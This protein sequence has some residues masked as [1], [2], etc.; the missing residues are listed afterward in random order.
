MVMR[1]NDNLFGKFNGA[2]GNVTFYVRDGKQVMAQRNRRIGNPR[3]EAQMAQRIKLAN[4]LSVYR[5]LRDKLPA[6][7][8][9]ASDGGRAPSSTVYNRFTGINLLT[10]PVFL[11][12]ELAR[13]GACVAAPYRV[14]DGALPAIQLTEGPAG[15]CTDILLGDLA[16]TEETS[17]A[18]FTEAVV[19][20]NPLYEEGDSIAYVHLLQTLPCESGVPR[21]TPLFYSVR[22]DAADRRPLRRLVPALGFSAR[23]G[24]L[25]QEGAV[26]S[27]AFAWIHLRKGCKG[28]V[29]SPQQLVAHNRLFEEYA[30][31]RA[32]E[33]ALR[34]YRT[35]EVAVAPADSTRSNR[36]PGLPPIAGKPSDS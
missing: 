6:C 27:C 8:E 25:A 19:R 24:R 28:V 31:E 32:A 9:S 5:L 11:T 23:E 21:V 22:L 36:C 30:S 13:E 26:E 3:T 15:A 18:R 16:L 29:A 10:R 20:L 12:R 17:V 33:E 4:I 14:S 7:F 35:A 2:V 1:T 34:S